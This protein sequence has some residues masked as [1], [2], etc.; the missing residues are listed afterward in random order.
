MNNLN[1]DA[2]IRKYFNFDAE[3]SS[4]IC[5][6]GDDAALMHFP[7][8]SCAISTDLFLQDAHFDADA[9]PEDVGYKALAV[10]L[11]DLAAMG[12]TPLCFTLAFAMPAVDESWIAK[13]SKGIKSLAREYNAVLIGGDMS[14]GEL[15]VTITIIGTFEGESPA[16][17]R[18]GA[19]VG[20]QI[21][22]TGTIG[23][24]TF[25]RH[26]SDLPGIEACKLRLH[27]PQPRVDFGRR[28]REYAHAAMD[29]SDGLLLDL[30][31]LLDA[32]KKG[33]EVELTHVPLSAPVATE[34]AQS[35]DWFKILGG[36]EDYELIFTAP[37]EHWPA[38]EQMGQELDVPVT[39]IGTVTAGAELQVFEQGQPLKLPEQL[40][41]DHFTNP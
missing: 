34:Q 22:V 36:G 31:R 5:G 20:D 14:R 3:A 9:D 29:V 19:Q 38:I 37:P 25:A 35:G 40:G 6:P 16:L 33:G 4:L 12:A 1:E 17:L 13:F 23:D 28:L 18:S 41:H 32:S 39:S 7:P 2:L 30:Q 26:H 21:G 27:R 15:A 10:N 24:A 11:S 8:G